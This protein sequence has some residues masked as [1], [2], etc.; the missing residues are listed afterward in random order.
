MWTALWAKLGDGKAGYHPLVCHL[1]DVLAVTERLWNDVLPGR[2]RA[3]V[4]HDLGLDEPSAGRW[5]AGLA[6]LHD[7]GKA[8]PAFQILTLP[9]PDGTHRR[10]LE[11]AGLSP[12]VRPAPAR[13]DVLAAPVVRD[14]LVARHGMARPLAGSIGLLLAGHH[15]VFPDPAQ[16]LALSS[17]LG[18]PRWAAARGSLA[19]AVLASAGLGPASTL[20]TALPPRTAMLV[21]GLVC[22][23]DWIGS[24]TEYFPYLVSD[25]EPPPSEFELNG[26]LA[27]ARERAARAVNQLGWAAVPA[28][29]QRADF[30][31]AFG[32]APRPLQVVAERLAAT[33]DGPGVVA[34]EA[35]TGEGK[36]EAALYL[37]DAWA[38]VG[39]TRGAYVALPTQATSDQMF[40]RVRTFLERRYPR[41][42]IDLQLLHGHAALSAE[43]ELLLR[44]GDRLFTAADVGRDLGTDEGAVVAGTWFTARKRGLLAPYGVGTVDQALL[45][46]LVARHVFVRLFGLAGKVV[47]L[48]EV[49]AYDTYM[50]TL[51]ERLLE[52]LGALGSS[53]I[54][55]SATLPEERRRGLL[56][57]YARGADLP[58]LESP[59]SAY[60][61]IS[62][63]AGGATGSESVGVSEAGRR[64]LGLAWLSPDRDGMVADEELDQLAARVARGG[65]CLAFVCNSVARA[66]ALYRRLQ[67]R[68]PGAAPDGAPLVDLLHARFP[69]DERAR[70]EARC[71]RRF[72]RRAA[73]PER[74]ILVA[75][76]VIEQSLDLDFDALVTDFAPI[77]LL[78][79]RAGRLQRHREHDDPRPPACDRPL[80]RIVGPSGERDGEPLFDSGT[81][82]VYEDRHVRLR[83]WLTLRERTTVQVPAEVSELIE[84]VYADKPAPADLT[85]V[86][87]GA[88][89]R[90]RELSVAARTAEAVEARDRW[91]RSPLDR[92]ATITEL[93]RNAFD[94]DLDGPPGASGALTRLGADSV[95]VVCLEA[96]P[97]GPRL[98]G[99]PVPLERPV[100]VSL[101]K[102]LLRRSLPIGQRGLV[103]LLRAR[104][105]P[106]GWRRSPL[107]RHARPL[108]FAGGQLTL[109]GTDGLAAYRLVLDPELGL[110]AE[111]LTDGDSE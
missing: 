48:D 13:H 85:P 40:S 28:S 2:T 72:G 56:D 17:A 12:G 90:T 5:V 35:P 36:T 29:S 61:R 79:Q 91:L 33:L 62:W 53:V 107:L 32:F 37:A 16:A 19:D 80:L 1:H 76:Q 67:A 77:D 104:P 8:S 89:E 55:L 3:W 108:T 101:A 92:G 6:G 59:V 78:L 97:D 82:A 99:D 46:A 63:R 81:I 4:A 64:V 88:W 45:A 66:Q 68:L 34:I 49:H 84:L 83:T 60:P 25:S 31:A 9:D 43:F 74:A 98:D 18:D 96:G 102:E 75:T 57:A 106:A 65:G 87:R 69:Y 21:A 105:V 47:V 100:P 70:R 109:E 27:R 22:V 71:L 23:A 20:P 110:V 15:G 26:Y 44:S 52:W 10:A 7:L 58:G 41:D 95:T 73:R 93:T 11:V 111:R 30:A 24:N 14:I 103:P 38:A 42:V 50:S 86:A 51:L 54:L 39:G 94:D